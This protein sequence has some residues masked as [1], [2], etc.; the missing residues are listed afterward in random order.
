MANDNFYDVRNHVLVWNGPETAFR[1]NAQGK[2]TANVIGDT[3]FR[4]PGRL[5]R[6]PYTYIKRNKVYRRVANTKFWGYIA[7][8]GYQE[9]KMTLTMDMIDLSMMYYLCKACTTAD[10]E[11]PVYVHSYV[12]T[13]AQTSPP[14]SFQMVY[15]IVNYESGN[16]INALFVGCVLSGVAIS[17]PR[18]GP[19][20]LT[21]DIKF[22]RVIASNSP[23]ALT[24]Y[25]DWGV[26]QEYHIDR[27]EWSIKKNG[28]AYPGEILSADIVYNDGT[29]LHKAANS[30]YAT[31]AI[32]G[33]P[34]IQVRLTFAPKDETFAAD[35][36]TAPL[37][38]ATASH[39]DIVI[40]MYR[41]TAGD[42]YTEFNFEKMWCID[43]ADGT[44]DFEIETAILMQH[45]TTFIIKPASFETGAQLTITERNAL[46]D[47]RYE[48]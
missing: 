28:T 14:P 24:A 6:I 23:V 35:T 46:D 3:F 5:L 45:Q 37:A 15:K 26:L 31:E 36:M 43:S 27:T 19:V 16:N 12:T 44:W 48:T 7:H 33:N 4:L 25:P 13:T 1:T 17:I 22:A 18:E 40:K 30:E 47:D 41:G 9:G 32:N 20:Q 8:E 10:G 11:A 42:D 29:V 39:I 38:P 2:D 34:D 21:L